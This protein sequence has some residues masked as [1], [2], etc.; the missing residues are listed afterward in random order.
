[1]LKNQVVE[2]T[3]I[4]AYALFSNAA[5]ARLSLSECCGNLRNHAETYEHIGQVEMCVHDLRPVWEREQ[6]RRR[7]VVRPEEAWV[8]YEADL[9]FP[10]PLIWE[11]LTNPALEA[12]FLGYDYA[13]RTDDLG[14]RVREESQFHCAHGDLHVYNKVVD[15]KPFEYYTLLQSVNT[16]EYF[17]TRRLV[18][19]KDGSRLCVYASK[20]QQDVSEE[21]RNHIQT[22]YDRGFNNLEAFIQQDIASGKVTLS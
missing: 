7:K 12:G 1:M 11:Y 2:Q 5:A 17:Q 22:E 4:R 8:K 14:G 19:T 3:G 10:P 21:L 9:P 18:L 20:P 15:W 16:L 13:E 6:A